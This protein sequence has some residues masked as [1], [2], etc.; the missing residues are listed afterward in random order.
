[1]G[2]A[3]A[4]ALRGVRGANPLVGAVLTAPDGSVLAVGH[5]RGRGTPH[6]EVD[7]IAAWRAAR[8]ADPV[9]AALDPAD[10]TLHVTLEPCD[11]TGSTGPCSQAVLDAGIG[12]LRY[13]VADPTG[14]EGGGAARLARNGVRVTGPT[15][16]RAAV[17]L[18]ARWRAA[19]AAGRPWVTAHLAQ[20]LDGCAA[21]AD[22]TSQWITGPAS[23]R[24]AHQVRARVD[25]IVVG[26][27]TV[28]AD[29]PRLTARGEDGSDLPAQPVPVVQGRRPVPAG[30]ALRRHPVVLEVPDHDPHAVLAALAAHPGPW[31]HGRRAEHVLIEGGPHILGAWLRAGLVDE[32]MAYTAPLL[33]GAGRPAV[34][35]LDVDTLAA[36]IRLVPDP[37]EDG[38]VRPLGA[39]TWTH[40]MPA[41]TEG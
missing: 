32:V 28:L 5:H 11:H 6:A 10:L 35:G 17:E 22:G 2:L 40:L 38:P 8:A 27:G 13:A 14:H 21:A 26:T 23:R 4:A 29:D 7:A 12:A 1:M 33:L 37:A 16:E 3:V 30:A 36:G 31:P 24:H 25:A 18:T 19:R 9:L 34:A 20:S 41:P 39:D 15:G